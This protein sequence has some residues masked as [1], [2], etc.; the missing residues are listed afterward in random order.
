MSALIDSNP[1]YAAVKLIRADWDTWGKSDLVKELGIK[2]RSTLIV[3]KDGAEVDR[4]VAQTDPARI[5]A[6]FQ[7]IT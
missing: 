7:S 3:Y 5:E 2:R 4:V 1:E 6:L